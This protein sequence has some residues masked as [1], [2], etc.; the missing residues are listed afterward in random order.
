M[1]LPK[2]IQNLQPY[3]PGKSIRDAAKE[4]GIADWIKLASNEN[5]RGV[6]PKAQK[7]AME[8]VQEGYL[9][10]HPRSPELLEVI[11]KKFGKKEDEI[12][13]A[14]GIDAL[15]SYI[16]MAFT[17][18]GEEI[19]TSAGSFIGIYVNVNKLGRVL[20]T[21]PLK[22]DAYDLD[23]ISKAITPSTKIIYL[24]NPNNPTGTAFG[25]KEW[26]TFF[27]KLPA[28]LI[29]IL[30]EAYY[31]YANHDPQYPNGLNYPLDRLIVTRT[32]SK[33]YGMANFRV[34][35]AFSSHKNIAEIQKVKLPFEPSTISSKAA[36][37]ALSD[38]EFLT[39]TQ[40]LNLEGLEFF[41]KEFERLGLSFVKETRGNFFMIRFDNEVQAMNF[42][43]RCLQN[44]LILRPL[45][46]FGIPN[47]VRIN[48]GTMEENKG[49]I[50]IIEKVLKSSG[51][52]Q[53]KS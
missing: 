34:G 19:L 13:C 35:Y 22:N 26:E 11:S 30:D 12:I 7:A 48:T 52:G 38:E 18:E 4:F 1:H 5:P 25:K 51:F 16:V 8:A 14:N 43:E 27:K 24:S 3:K 31:E 33:A 42:N 45:L 17:Y 28:H 39:S 37:A 20:Q 49:A 53:R 50:Q 32:F 6:S 2:H 47:G 23:A 29:V 44:G 46:A 36:A 40:K 9:Y 10:P 41:K 15:L 21:V